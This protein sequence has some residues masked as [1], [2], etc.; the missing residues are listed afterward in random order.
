MLILSLTAYDPSRPFPYSSNSL[1]SGTRVKAIFVPRSVGAM[2]MV[3]ALRPKR[4]CSHPASPGFGLKWE[5]HSAQSSLMVASSTP[6]RK[7]PHHMPQARTRFRR[8]RRTSFIESRT[9]HPRQ[10]RSAA[11]R[12][13]EPQRAPRAA[14]AMRSRKL[15]VRSSASAGF[16]RVSRKTEFNS[17]KAAR[18]LAADHFLS[19]ALSRAC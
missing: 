11:C 16:R 4:R 5:S 8:I 7:V 14:F 18:R 15:A 17:L 12:K 2:P 1:A 3:K 13:R 10:V 6:R 9:V 19:C